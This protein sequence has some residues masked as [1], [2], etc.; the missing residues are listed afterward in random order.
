MA[1]TQTGTFGVVMSFNGGLTW[2]VAG[3]ARAIGSS[4]ASLQRVAKRI[5]TQDDEGNTVSV[6]FY[7]FGK[8]VNIQCYPKGT[9]LANGAT[10]N[11]V[12]VTPGTL[13][14]LTSSAGADQ[15]DTVLAATAG[16]T[17]FVGSFTK[18]HT[19][20]DK[21]RWDMTLEKPDAMTVATIT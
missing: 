20:G 4:S 8:T 10:V 11:S 21:V 15:E 9:T 14:V 2:T 13:V 12:D 3:T 1:S 16:T 18:T 19:A 7:D 5:D 17:Y 6:C